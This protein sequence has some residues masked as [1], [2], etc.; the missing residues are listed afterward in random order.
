MTKVYFSDVVSCL[1]HTKDLKSLLNRK[2]KNHTLIERVQNT[3]YLLSNDINRLE[4]YNLL[5]SLEDVF[6]RMLNCKDSINYQH[7]LEMYKSEL[8]RISDYVNKKE[9]GYQHV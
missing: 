2:I 5:S 4:S 9:K 8:Q 7:T 6:H 1:K 3:K